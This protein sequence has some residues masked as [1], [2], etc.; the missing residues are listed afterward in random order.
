MDVTQTLRVMLHAVPFRPFTVCLRDGRQ[1]RVDGPAYLLITR[2]GRIVWEGKDSE[3]EF[4]LLSPQQVTGI[5]P[6]G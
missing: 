5:E 3:R 1:L 6:V 4:A 2:H